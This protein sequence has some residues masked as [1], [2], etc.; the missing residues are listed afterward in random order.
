MMVCVAAS[1]VVRSYAAGSDNTRQPVKVRTPEPSLR[2]RTIVVGLPTPQGARGMLTGS[3]DD[4]KGFLRDILTFVAEYEGLTVRF[5]ALS[6]PDGADVQQLEDGRIDVL[7]GVT[8]NE[9]NL[10]RFR[11]TAPVVVTPGVAITRKGTKAPTTVAELRRLSLVVPAGGAG[12]TFAFEQGLPAQPRPTFPECF[13]E[14]L[15]GRADAMLTTQLAANYQIEKIGEPLRDLQVSILEPIGFRR[16]YAY[17]VRA[18]DPALLSAIES[19]LLALHQDGRFRRAYEEEV[20]RYQPLEGPRSV[21][22]ATVLHVASVAGGVLLVGGG[23]WQWRTRRR[24]ASMSR[25]LNESEERYRRIFDQSQDAIL[26]VDP[27]SQIVLEANPAAER[28]YGYGPGEMHGLDAHKLLVEP[29]DVPDHIRKVVSERSTKFDRSKHRRRDGRLVLIDVHAA[30]AT[31]GGREVIVAINRDVTATSS[32]EELIRSVIETSPHVAIQAFDRSGCVH[33]WNEASTRLYGWSAKEAIG[34][35]IGDL[36]GTPDDQ[37]AIE[38]LLSRLEVD[39]R[40]SGVMEYQVHSKTGEPRWVL[41]EIVPAPNVQGELQFVCVDIDVSAMKLAKEK[42][43]DAQAKLASAL[44]AAGMG[45]WSIDLRAGTIDADPSLLRLLGLDPALSGPR[46]ISRIG[47][48]VHPE[49][50]AR[51]N[52]ALGATMRGEAPYSIENRIVLSSDVTRWLSSRAK[53]IRD[54]SGEVVAVSGAS[55]DITDSKLAAADAERLR[56]ELE[57]ARRLES[58]GLLAGG[59][60]HDFNNLLVGIRGNTELALNTLEPG[61]TAARAL[62]L[63]VQATDRT[64]DLTSQLLS[65][66]GRNRLAPERIDLNAIVVESVAL[67]RPRLGRGLTIE[68]NLAEPTVRTRADGAQTRQALSNLLTNAA[69]ALGTTGGRIVVRTGTVSLSSQD[70]EADAF[71]VRSTPGEYAFIEVADNGCGMDDRV[72]AKVFD[73]FY[74]TK[75]TGRG[76]GLSLVMMTIRRHEGAI[77]IRSTPGEGTTCTLLLPLVESVANPP[78]SVEPVAARRKASALIIDD[79]AMVRQVIAGMLRLEGWSTVEVASGEEGVRASA[80]ERFDIVFLDLTMPGMSGVDTASEIRKCRP[81]MPIVFVSGYSREMAETSTVGGGGLF[82]DEAFVQKPFDS[83]TLQAAATEACE[84]CRRAGVNGAISVHAP[85][86][87]GA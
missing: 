48:S 77:R 15:A 45:T 47:E 82:A 36:I 12:R 52:D 29:A 38:E 41:S 80:G 46:P 28:T 23:L 58:L 42:L 16:A 73:P 1:L 76:L 19:G 24:Q 56:D 57:R 78:A 60:A 54:A 26:I 87:H 49:D 13:D 5:V 53:Y 27:A 85:S 79:E 81:D 74:S 31:I 63:V 17:A 86:Q 67:L 21:E 34:R 9:N 83:A 33:F 62:D 61:S 65:A 84:R 66:A 43:L 18:D 72:L 64:A 8:V 37:A 35:K 11:L 2:T 30:M 6:A 69:D 4:P 32:Y 75:A 59:L 51:V 25:V 10:R 3:P 70:F 39:R 40:P 71:K 55:I 68:F 50:R 14:V 7:A 20:A 22:L 44:E